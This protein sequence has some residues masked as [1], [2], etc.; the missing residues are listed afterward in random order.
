MPLAEFVC[1]EPCPTDL[2]EEGGD[3]PDHET[4]HETSHQQ[5]RLV[6]RCDDGGEKRL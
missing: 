4:A 3:Q 1:C 6:V 5:A 2:L